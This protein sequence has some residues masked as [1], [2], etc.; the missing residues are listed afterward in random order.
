MDRSVLARKPMTELKDI[1]SHLN[2]RGFQKLRKA[3]LIDA[4]VESATGQAAAST[5]GAADTTEVDDADADRT[6]SRTRTRARDTEGQSGEDAA[7]DAAPA[8]EDA[9][10]RA[11]REETA[12]KV[13]PTSARQSDAGGDSGSEKGQADKKPAEKS[14]PEERTR[15]RERN[16]SRGAN[17]SGD[18]GNNRARGGKSDGN[19]DGGRDSGG[20][21][22]GG[23][24]SGGRDGGGRDSGGRDSGGRDS[25][26]RDSGRDS[27]GRDSGRDSN[28]GGKGEDR[29]RDGGRKDDDR[30]RSDAPRSDNDSS[31][32]DDDDDDDDAA[33]RKRRSRRDRRKRNRERAQQENQ[34]GSSGGGGGNEPGEVRAGVL[35]ILPEGYGFLRTTGY[36]PG[37]RDVYVSQGQIRKH[38]LRRGDVVQGPIRQQRN[39][40]KVPALHHVQKVNGGELEGGQVPERPDFRD[41]VPVYPSEQLRLE[42]EK[43]PTVLRAIDL[44]API[45]RGQRALL[46][47]P[48][49]AGRTDT[50]K[51]IGQAIATNAP[52]AH[53]MVLLIDERPED[54]TD[55]KRAIPG[56]VIASTFDRPV[57]DHT[58]VAELA[59]ERARRLVELGHDVVV[60]VDSL[61]RLTRAYGSGGIDAT[62]LYPAKRF[63]GSARK[64]EDGGSLTI[65]AAMLTGDGSAVDEA[66]LEE[67]L[68]TANAVIHLD[69]DVTPHLRPVVRPD[70][71]ATRREELLVDDETLQAIWAVRKRLADLPHDE[72]ARTIAS[73]LE[74]TLDNA[75]YLAGA[76]GSSTR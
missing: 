46:V 47:A 13:L 28:A 76:G 2:M 27:G 44:L 69:G 61:T 66:I 15:S 22:S 12:R 14:Q 48:P 33:N 62:S 23:R 31:N 43:A 17:R 21:D 10:A 26:G 38:G 32:D 60:L 73:D 64:I 52:E 24:D 18:N 71:S 35:D 40:E 42:T 50:L 30:G 6:R 29:P 55:V 51:G 19:R 74:G 68:G 75:T 59:M 7:S 16:T 37:D 39:N 67:F 58:Q 5:N 9:A 11:A 3:E 72:A 41:L 54:V 45:G 25:G 34:Q 63:F 57:E 1:A 36:T 20:R 8:G 4:I 49:A 65:V 56:E 53:L 70:T